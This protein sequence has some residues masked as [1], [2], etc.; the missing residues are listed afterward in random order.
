MNSLII[1]MYG[2]NTVVNNREGGYFEEWNTNQKTVK[3]SS[4]GYANVIGQ[5]SKMFATSELSKVVSI[6]KT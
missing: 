3:S 5:V 4:V 2:V 6:Q 1:G